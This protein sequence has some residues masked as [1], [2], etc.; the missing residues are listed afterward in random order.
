LPGPIGIALDDLVAG[1]WALG[2][3]HLLNAT[4]F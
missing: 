4:V 3:G 1:V 2:I